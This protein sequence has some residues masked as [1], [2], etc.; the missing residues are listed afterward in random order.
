MNMFITVQIVIVLVLAVL[1]E[2]A[3]LP[4][5][6]ETKDAMDEGPNQSD[7]PEGSVANTS[8]EDDDYSDSLK[9]DE[10]YYKVRLLNTGD[11]F[12]GLMG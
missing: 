5:A 12:Y 8:T 1:S 3:S 7:E 9:Q 2:A 6:T 11:K 4:T 10:K